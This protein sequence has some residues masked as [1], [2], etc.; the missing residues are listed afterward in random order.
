MSEVTQFSQ[1]FGFNVSNLDLIDIIEINCY[2]TLLDEGLVIGVNLDPIC[3]FTSIVTSVSSTIGL[4]DAEVSWLNAPSNQVIV[5]G[6]VNFLYSNDNMGNQAAAN[7]VV[8][9][10]TEY[11]DLDLEPNQLETLLKLGQS[12]VNDIVAFIEENEEDVLPIIELTLELEN[13]DI[14]NGLY[15]DHY[16]EVINEQLGDSDYP[17]IPSPGNPLSVEIAFS[18]ECASLRH[19]LTNSGEEMSDFSFKLEAMKRTFLNCV[20]GLFDGL[21][22]FPGAGEIFDIANGVIYTLEGKGTEASLSFAAALPITGWFATASKFAYK[23]IPGR[24]IKLIWI[25]SADGLK[26]LFP[27]KSALRG[28]LRR[29]LGTPSGDIAH[30]IIPLKHV[31]DEGAQSVSHQMVQKAAKGSTETSVPWHPNEAVTDAAGNVVGGNG[32][33]LSSSLHSGG[34]EVYTEKIFNRMEDVWEQL[35]MTYGSEALVPS[36]VAAESMREIVNDIRQAIINNP[37]TPLNDLIF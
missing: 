23:T 25:K 10:V 12:A 3:A 36:D 1:Q 30:H 17:C 18:F 15:D 26:V 31:V 13:Q 32:I 34:H 27:S 24:T 16:L 7:S 37:N 8:D 9:L 28:Q 2:E 21:G 35:K 20:H 5:T 33:S 4:D 11:P 22:L 14:I 29:I 19:Q 6:I